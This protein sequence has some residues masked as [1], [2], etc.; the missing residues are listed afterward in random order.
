MESN[1][2][3][4]IFEEIG[5]LLELKGENPFKSRAY[6]N[7]ARTIRSMG[8]KRLR[9]LAREDR[10]KEVEGIGEAIN[11]KLKELLLTGFLPYYGELR[12]SVPP[13]LHDILL[14]PGLG[15][16]KTWMLYNTLGISTLDELESACKENRLAGLRGFSERSQKNILQGI[17]HVRNSLG[18]YHYG[19]ALG[20]ANI[21]MEGLGAH[22]GFGQV[23]LAGSIRRCREVVKD[24][25]LVA[26]AGNPAKMTAFFAGLSQV[27]GV[28]AL[29]E[30]KATVRLHKGIK[31]DLRVV[32][33]EE[34]PFA[35]HHFTGSKEHNTALRQRAKTM[36][37][38]INEY[39]IFKG[40]ELLSCRD[41]QELFA[42]LDLAYIPPELREN[43]G[44]IEA[45]EKG[46]LPDLVEEKDIKG[47]FHIHTT[48]SDGINTLEEIVYFCRETGY[49]YVGITDHSISAHYAGGLSVE[50]LLGQVEE[51]EGLRGKFPELAIFS[52]VE[53][54]I[55][56]DGSLDYADEVL[57]KLDFV[58]ASI[59]SGFRMTREK[60]TERLVRALS[61]PQ[62]TM[63]G[64]PTGRLLLEREGYPLDL[65]RV[66]LAA[67]EHGV[68]IELNANPARLDL[69][70]R[71]LKR[72]K[73]MGVLVSINPDAHSLQDF[74]DI[75]FGISIARKGWL[76]KKDVFNTLTRQEVEAYLL[77][78][79][80]S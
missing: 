37:L 10:L 65:E 28:I 5:R 68:I 47:I 73:D 75:K 78:R 42:T 76:E 23:N 63:L 11:D 64:H 3:V 31:A 1:S 53:V 34:F 16:K 24:I 22:V 17:G 41:E 71:H 56:T 69:D 45:A 33:E 60:M 2:V 21:L 12:E 58:I 61:H 74:S 80:R 70:W 67:L 51:I 46:V 72:A 25:D 4:K 79:K 27:A 9:D 8:E 52:G 39:G 66:L 15:P 32:K 36:G 59:H 26:F 29:G 50:E 13:G 62:V 49:E 19:M 77:N 6:Y 14:V 43:L 38:K 30:T 54:D 48:S 20:L 44:E 40:E 55:R 57:Q 35:L 18:Y 7:V